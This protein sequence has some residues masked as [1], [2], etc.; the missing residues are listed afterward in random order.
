MTWHHF[1][2]L[3]I[4]C[5]KKRKER[6]GGRATQIIDWHFDFCP[7]NTSC[8]D[9]PDLLIYHTRWFDTSFIYGISLSSINNLYSKMLIS[10]IWTF[11]TT[12]F[13]QSLDWKA[14]MLFKADR[15]ASTIYY[16]ATALFPFNLQ[17]GH[18]TCKKR[19]FFILP[20]LQPGLL[21]FKR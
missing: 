15:F 9:M 5:L 21:L 2:S 6:E 20:A 10:K 16:T 18:H 3:T 14:V 7:T 13:L 11:P 19:F 4:L 17:I 1:L 8:L 12:T